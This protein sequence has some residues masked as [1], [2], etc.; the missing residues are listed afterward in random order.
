[1]AIVKTCSK[2]QCE[3][4]VNPLLSPPGGLIKTGGLFEEGG[5]GED[6]FNLAKHGGIGSPL[7]PRI[8][9]GKVQVQE[10]GGHAAE[11][12]KQLAELPVGE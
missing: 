9:N 3:N 4:T 5:G 2:A 11:D 12:Q 6:L 1:M 7:R 8:K 10:V